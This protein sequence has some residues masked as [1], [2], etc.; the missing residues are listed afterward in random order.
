MA[1]EREMKIT[2]D[3]KEKIIKAAIQILSKKGFQASPM[4]LIAKK[5]Q[6]ATGTIYTYFKNKDQLI[7]SCFFFIEDEII[8][9]LSLKLNG[10]VS[11]KEQVI[12]FWT[13]LLNYIIANPTYFAYLEQFHNSPYGIS[14]R[15]DRIVGIGNN[16]PSIFVSVMEDGIKK[17]E[18][19]EMPMTLLCALVFGPI[20][21]LSRDH[22]LGFT[23]LNDDLI[24]QGAEAC[25]KSLVR[26]E[27]RR[28]A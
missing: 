13:E 23:K 8:N 7:K 14:L 22:L 25:W 1:K 18:I 2:K 4:P 27:K 19:K 16:E 26:I 3:K 20:Y 17:K 10:T 15:K 28:C 21:F 6:V 9:C 11:V 5:A 12:R 24:K